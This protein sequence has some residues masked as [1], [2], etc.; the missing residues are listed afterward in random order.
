MSVPNRQIGWSNESNLLW[1]IAK[2]LEKLIKVVANSP[3]EY[4][5]SLK[6]DK[7]FSS[8][9]S[10]TTPLSGTEEIAIV[11]GGETK[12]VA[13]S[14]FGGTK[15]IRTFY[16]QWALT[17]DLQWYS[18]SL[19]TNA[20][21]LVGTVV[22]S[23]GSGTEPN[24]V[25]TWFADNTVFF[26]KGYKKLKRVSFHTR[27][28]NLPNDI[29]LLVWKGDYSNDRGNELNGQYLVNEVFSLVGTASNAKSDF[30]IADHSLNDDSVLIFF[31]RRIGGTNVPLIHVQLIFEFE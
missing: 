21:K 5:I 2:Q 13:V 8:L 17:T 19:A 24:K 12:K 18:P 1:Q 20:N 30:N 10:A 27:R 28:C 16:G 23:Y 6:L 3:L 11:Q 29:Q 26:L 15:E 22:G 4:L 9:T 7:N 25:L 14:E 31:F